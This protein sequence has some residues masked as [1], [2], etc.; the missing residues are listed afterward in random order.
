MKEGGFIYANEEN[1]I[2]YYAVIPSTVLFNKNLKANEKLL[3]AVITVMS[4]KEGYCFAQNSYLAKLF[5]C[6]P[7]TISNWIA[8]LYKLKFVCV[9]FI[10]NDKNEIIQ[11]RIYPNDIPYVIK[12]TYPY[13]IN[14]TEGMSQKRQYNNNIYNN[15]DR[16]FY[17]IINKDK[18]NPEKFSTE[19][20]I[21]FKNLIKNLDLNY[22]EEI[23]EGF[24][25]D[26]IE[27]IKIII[28]ALKELFLSNKKQL[29]TKAKRDN[30]IF[31][32]DGCKNRE[33][34][35][36]G[37]EKE[38]NNFFEYYYTSLIKDLEKT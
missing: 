28:F 14:M 33:Q 20:E 32:Y 31:L 15:I 12:M 9:E 16:F 30:L 23:I 11:R 13:T 35:Y 37:T 34:E 5:N 1:Q 25:K 21:D 26:N 8:N 17:Y 18:Q 27:K 19:E 4:N 24:T 3:Y 29:I 6:E 38:I 22:T 7:H 36:K 2:G 10:K